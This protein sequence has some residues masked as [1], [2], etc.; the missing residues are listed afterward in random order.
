VGAVEV[1]VPPLET[2][3]TPVTSELKEARPL[4]SDPP[5]VDL[6]K[7][8]VRLVRVVEPRELTERKVV[9]EELA[10]LKIS[11]VAAEDVP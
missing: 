5:A 10:T 4:K 11:R 9:L 8:V 2:G 7:P 6:T 1:P 3:K